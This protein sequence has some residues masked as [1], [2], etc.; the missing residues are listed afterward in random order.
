[1][2]IS[3]VVKHLDDNKITIVIKI[4]ALLCNLEKLKQYLDKR[5]A[6]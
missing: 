3:S 2:S 6:I 5:V 4:Q 1:M